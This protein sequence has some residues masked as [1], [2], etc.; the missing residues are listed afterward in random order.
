M[1]ESRRSRIIRAVVMMLLA[2][3][4]ALPFLMVFSVSLKTESD[5][6][7]T[8]FIPNLKAISF[9]N[10]RKVWK[11]ANIPGV[12]FSSLLITLGSMVGQV[13]FSSM[14]AYALTKMRFSRSK[15]FSSLFM[16]PLVFSVQTV[17]FPI[18]MVYKYT[19]LLNTYTGLILIYTAT[20]LA[21]SIFIFVKF[22]KSIPF[23]ISEAAMID[24][25][26]HLRIFATIILPMSKAQISTLAIVNGLGVWNDFFLPLMLFTNGKISTLPLSMYT[27]TTEYGKKWTLVSAD[28]VFMLLPILVIYIFLQKYIVE[29]VSAGAVKG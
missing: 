10:Y 17:I 18:F 8:S 21:T 7:K 1:R 14:A 19:G 24:G 23:E 26:G 29:G 5:F 13:L 28:I 16:I 2:L 9:E 12:T 6:A 15:L 11:D 27:F 20:G 4:V 25:A 3:I 22:F